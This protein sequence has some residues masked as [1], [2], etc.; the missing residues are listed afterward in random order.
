[1]FISPTSPLEPSDGA[2]AL[3]DRSGAVA[4]NLL[5]SSGSSSTSEFV[6]F[7][8][9]PLPTERIALTSAEMTV[10]SSRQI[11]SFISGPAMGNDPVMP[12]IVSHEEVILSGA[13]A[14]NRSEAAPPELSDIL[15]DFDLSL[16][17]DIESL[18]GV[19]ASYFDNNGNTD[20]TW[21]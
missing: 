6:P 2:I 1:M 20:D 13:A 3:D 19:S 5:I 10:D 9:D 11:T 14:L 16:W 8:Q 4:E 21:Q 7:E 12:N 17:D 15:Q 18:I